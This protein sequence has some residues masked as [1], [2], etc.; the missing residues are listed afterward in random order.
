[1]EDQVLK[2]SGS[3]GVCFVLFF[4]SWKDSYITATKYLYYCSTFLGHGFDKT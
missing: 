4:D 1:M 2:Q 3:M